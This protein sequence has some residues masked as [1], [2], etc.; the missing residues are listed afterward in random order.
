MRDEITRSLEPLCFERTYPGTADQVRQVRKDLAPMLDGCPV[1]DD[2]LLLLSEVV[3]NAVVHSRSR[4][5]GGVFT[6]RFVVAPDHFAWLE[7]EDQGGPWIRLEPDE[8]GG[9]G[10]E[11]VAALAGERNWAVE[12]GS[13]P[14]SRVVRLWLGWDGP[15]ASGMP[16]VPPLGRLGNTQGRDDAVIAAQCSCGFTELADEEIMDH[17]HVVFQPD[18]LQGSDGLAHEEHGRLTCACGLSA[19]TSDEL[20]EHFLKVFI[21]GD[22]IG[23]DGRRHEPPEADNDA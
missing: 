18:D 16:A 21:P 15:P 12:D 1:A 2:F 4:L 8:E 20:D 23:R 19:I 14:G 3:T 7:V 17:L 11:L 6:V 5:P 10:L 22:T 13:T 9:R